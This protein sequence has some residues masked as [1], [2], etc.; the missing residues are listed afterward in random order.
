M[1][2]ND[3]S[4]ICSAG[5]IKD[6]RNDLQTEGESNAEWMRLNKLSLNANKTEY[7]I[8]GHKRYINYIQGEI[9]VEIDWEK[10][11]RV[12]AVRH[13]GVTVDENFT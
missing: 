12:H 9:Q 2:A 3:T 8:T 13:L 1:Y 11:Q 7:M 4:V 10:S 5:G 6:L